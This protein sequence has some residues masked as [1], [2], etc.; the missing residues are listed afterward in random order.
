MD[1]GYP[2]KC[3]QASGD[4]HS[5]RNTCSPRTVSITAIACVGEFAVD[6]R[7][8]AEI[9]GVLGSALGCDWGT[10]TEIVEIFDRCG[11][12]VTHMQPLDE[13]LSDG[14]ISCEELTFEGPA[15]EL[16]REPPILRSQM[17]LVMWC[18]CEAET[19][20]IFGEDVHWEDEVVHS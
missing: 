20:E 9:K 13:L 12:N 5:A 8:L 14:G 10:E 18:T 3:T 1:A 11:L 4:T 6:T 2:S 19:V 7:H 15:E 16:I 17:M